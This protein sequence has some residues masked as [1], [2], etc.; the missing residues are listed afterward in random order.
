MMGFLFCCF[1]ALMWF[2]VFLL[3]CVYVFFNGLLVVLD[4]F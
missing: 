3:F 4:V 1:F 2:D